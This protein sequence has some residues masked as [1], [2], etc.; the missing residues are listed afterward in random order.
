MKNQAD[1]ELK[2]PLLSLDEADR[3][4]LRGFYARRHAVAAYP[5]TTAIN[6]PIGSILAYLACWAG[7]SPNAVT[8]TGALVST[9]GVI[10]FYAV[11]N[12]LESAVLAF[13]LLQAGYSL[14][15]ADGQLARGTHRTSPFGAW[16]DVALDFWV[17]VVV[18]IAVAMVA[19]QAG[20]PAWEALIAAL[21]AVYGRVLHLHTSTI[22]RSQGG[23]PDLKNASLL[24]RLGRC[25]LDPGMYICAICIFRPAP[26]LL[27][28]VIG[29]LGA[30]H[31]P[32]AFRM[33]KK[34]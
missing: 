15:C 16:L 19:Y 1:F 10:A 3:L 21:L 8:W 4:S 25:V 5:W 11:A 17:I 32:L 12:P 18:A 2:V 28:W 33:A 31:V 30:L 23:S 24:V 26:T 22:R 13:V 29:G 7:M 9:A 14:D 6:E 27:P 34:L 20:C